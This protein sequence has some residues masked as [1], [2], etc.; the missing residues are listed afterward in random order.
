MKELI[1]T[2]VKLGV[3][4]GIL[5]DIYVSPVTGDMLVKIYFAKNV[6]KRQG[7]EILPATMMEPST[8]KALDRQVKHYQRQLVITLEALNDGTTP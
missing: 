1:G 7:A 4:H 5:K 6:F 2:P 3:W 8:W